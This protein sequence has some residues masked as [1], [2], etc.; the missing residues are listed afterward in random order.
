[1]LM[2]QPF[3][4]EI[5]K[6]VYG[7]PG[8]GRH[9]GKVV[10]VPFS[11]PGDVLLAK[12][13]EEKKNFIRAMAVR[14][15]RAGPGRRQP[16]CPHFGVCGGCQWQHLEYHVQVETK[17]QILEETIRHHFPE[18]RDLPIHM[19]ASPQEFGYRSRAR[20]QVRGFGSDARAGFFRS[21]SRV[22]EDI[23]ECPLLRPTLNRGIREIREARRAGTGDP[24]LQQFE[25]ACSEE[26]NLWGWSE[27]QSDLDES[28]SA[29]TI[30]GDRGSE[31]V[32]SRKIGGFVYSLSPS[33]FFQAND[34]MIGQLVSSV[35]ELTQTAEKG[36]AVDLYCGV[37]LF[38]LPL[39]LRFGQVVAVE[40]SAAASSLCSKNAGAS[41]LANIRIICADV[42]AW[43]KAVGSVAP[44]AS[45]LLLLNPPRTGAGPEV[46][47]MV[48]E[49]APENI[50]YISCD[51]Q[52]L[53]RDLAALPTPDFRIDHIEG[54]DLF[55]QGYHFETVVRLRRP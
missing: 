11:V 47:S 54:L 14:I 46:M 1:M 41:G 39:G 51:P 55:P 26:E 52:T 19:R 9:E 13:V 8:L 36:T 49:W 25:I 16:H 45:S 28:I 30:A 21:Q 40:H 33:V 6:L 4:V 12:A 23:D 50:I 2:N 35:L 53:C 42:C 18:T 37:G 15:I 24:G 22:I 48:A 3:E 32:F 34:F 29:L 20:I 43:M 27:V 7:G 10:F 5:L 38:S 17:R 31:P 44:P